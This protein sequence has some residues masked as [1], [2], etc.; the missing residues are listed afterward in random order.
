[1]RLNMRNMWSRLN[2]TRG[3]VRMLHGVLR[4]LTRR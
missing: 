3:D 1:M 2:L 4:Q